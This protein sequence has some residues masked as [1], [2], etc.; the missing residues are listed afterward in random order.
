MTRVLQTSTLSILPLAVCLLARTTFGFQQNF[1]LPN[2]HHPVHGSTPLSAPLWLAAKGFGGGGS[3]TSNNNKTKKKVK[4][5]DVKKTQQKILKKYGSNVAEGTQRRVDAALAKLPPHL[6]M[7]TQLYQQLLKWD[8]RLANMSVLQQA[9]LPQVE[10]EGAQ[11]A[12]DELTKVYDE[13]DLDEHDLHNIFQQITWDASA[14]AKAARAI[15]AGGE[16]A[17]PMARKIDAACQIV[18]AAVGKDGHCLDVGCGYGV[19]V[20]HLEQAGLESSQIHGIDLSQEMI[21]NARQLHRGVDFQATDFLNEYGTTNDDTDEQEQLQPSQ[22]ESIIF[23]AA[24]HDFSDM[25][26]ALQKASTLLKLNGKLVIS[27]PQGASHVTRQSNA[28]PVMVKRSLYTAQELHSVVKE[29]PGKMTVELEP[30]T[31]NSPEEDK[32]GYLAVLTKVE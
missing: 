9:Q 16:M 4:K 12:R 19:L 22:F 14:D 24:L 26:S 1:K 20:P 5:S 8:Q 13:Y 3:S 6:Y 10:M 7:A 2:L 29:L 30:A 25:T 11:R 15:I 32:V 23:C 28:N 27:H 21:K 17:A 31:P 18:A